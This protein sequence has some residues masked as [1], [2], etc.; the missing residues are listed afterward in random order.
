MRV[1]TVVL[2]LGAF[3]LAACAHAESAA[4]RQMV[5]MRESMDKLEV[6]RDRAVLPESPNDARVPPAPAARTGKTEPQR[7]VQIGDEGGG[8]ESDD[9]DDPE[10][11]PE[12]KLQGAGGAMS[13]PRPRPRKTEAT[14]SAPK[15]NR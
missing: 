1:S 15:E 3:F 2:G 11:R 13:A 9:P 10:A 6:E 8:R 5:E 4:D 14:K 7:T 12:I